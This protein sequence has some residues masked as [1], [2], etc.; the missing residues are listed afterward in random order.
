MWRSALPGFEA[1]SMW[2]TGQRRW[3][4]VYVRKL[5]RDIDDQSID[6]EIA[7]QVLGLPSPEGRYVLD[8]D[9]YQSIQPQGDTLEVGG[10]PDSQ[11]T[12]IDRRT[13]LEAILEACGTSCGFHWGKWLSPTSFALGGWRDAD[14]F[15]Q[16][17]QGSLS[18]YSLQDSSVVTY[19][20]RVVSADDYARYV[21]AWK[22]WLMTRYRDL[23]GSR[24]QT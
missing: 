23:R 9:W 16:W 4:P 24:P 1:D 18:I 6:G 20:T 17:K 13:R 2:A 3:K 7:F 14:D 15:G 12:L 11:P 8:V 10:E 5:E 19:E 22:A 21:G